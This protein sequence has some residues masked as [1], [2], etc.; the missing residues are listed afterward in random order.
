MSLIVTS[1]ADGLLLVASILSLLA[2]IGLLSWGLRLRRHNHQLTIAMDNM[3]QGLCMFD[4]SAR[5]L[6]GN[7]RYIELY[8]LSSKKTK[9][10]SSL[11][12]LLKQ[13]IAAGTF[14]GDPDKYIANIKEE[15]APGKP[16]DKV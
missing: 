8:R 1:F 7:K 12:E 11:R 5:L 3:S 2:A 10:G 14:F 4:S 13:R 6:V 16:V 9:P 15:L